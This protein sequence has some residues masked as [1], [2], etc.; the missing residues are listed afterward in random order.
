MYTAQT[1]IFNRAYD[2][3]IN[4]ISGFFNNDDSN[5]VTEISY[6]QNRL[7]YAIFASR[8]FLN[9]FHL[10]PPLVKK[11]DGFLT[12]YTKWLLRRPA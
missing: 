11:F 2:E 1:K 6:L 7:F 3:L 12:S 5:P 8:G 10:S 4:A 9:L